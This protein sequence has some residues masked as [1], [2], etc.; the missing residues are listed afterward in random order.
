M[1]ERETGFISGKALV[2]GVMGWP[3]GHSLSPRLHGY[4]LRRYGIDGAYVPFAVDPAGAAEAIRALPKLGMR[5][6][7]V[8][9]P[10]KET[11]YAC[12]DR[13][14]V[15]AQRIG[16]V[17]T[18]IVEADG[19]LLGDCTDGYGFLEN[20]T[21][22]APH[23]QPKLSPAVVIGAGGSSRAVVASLVDAGVPEIRLVN[24]GR[25]RALQLARDCGGPITV[26]DWED[27]AAALQDVGLLVNSTSQGMVGEPPLDLSL[28]RLP[29]SAVVSDLIYVPL[30]TSLL[31]NARHRGCATVG[32]LGMLLHQ[33]R[34]G[35]AAWFGVEPEVDAA[36]EAHV[37]R[38]LLP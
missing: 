33:A 22:N 12:S 32:G 8:T 37:L 13:L 36:L 24:R 19:S 15:R 38:A 21:T 5:G 2:A 16:A 4:W 28:D 25:E 17:N 7:N 3:V 29:S 34:P 20:L 6:V 26:L 23:W 10:H 11:A 35:F 18:L 14:T 30:E 31:A 27:R 1:N 9:I